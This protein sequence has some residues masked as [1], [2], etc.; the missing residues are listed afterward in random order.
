MHPFD[1]FVRYVDERGWSHEAERRPTFSAS[2][3]GDTMVYT[4]LLFRNLDEG[5]PSTSAFLSLEPEAGRLTT[6][7]LTPQE[8][9]ALFPGGAPS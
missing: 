7:Y 6:T 5:R 2:F 3:R 9:A 8:T 4:Y 1:R